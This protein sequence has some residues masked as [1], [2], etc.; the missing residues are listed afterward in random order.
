MRVSKIAITFII[1]K[2]STEGAFESTRPS[3]NIFITMILMKRG[4]LFNQNYKKK[5]QSNPR[6]KSLSN[7]AK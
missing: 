2:S 1:A 6:N 5:F 4:S 7:T 3:I